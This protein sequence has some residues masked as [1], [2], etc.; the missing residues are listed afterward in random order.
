[1]F[2]AGGF[3]TIECVLDHSPPEQGRGQRVLSFD[4]MRRRIQ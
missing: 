3:R 2:V 4:Q 1:M